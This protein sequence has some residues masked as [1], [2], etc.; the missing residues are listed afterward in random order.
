MAIKF[1]QTTTKQLILFTK[2]TFLY[3][4]NTFQNYQPYL[5]NNIPLLTEYDIIKLISHLNHHKDTTTG[6]ISKKYTGF[7]VLGHIVAH[8][9]PL[10][11]NSLG[12]APR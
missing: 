11:V 10:C 12:L 9:S 5:D 2:H 3:L 4:I 7:Y 6:I 1:I 8:L